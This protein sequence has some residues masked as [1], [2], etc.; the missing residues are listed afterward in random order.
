M[1]VICGRSTP[2]IDAQQFE[3]LTKASAQHCQQINRRQLCRRRCRRS[4]L[5][6]RVNRSPIRRLAGDTCAKPRRRRLRFAGGAGGA[7]VRCCGG[8]LERDGAHVDEEGTR[9]TG[10]MTAHVLD[11]PVLGDRVVCAGDDN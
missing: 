4:R 3:V 1:C 6:C 11:E 9:A 7:R 2:P 8:A 5:S 10:R